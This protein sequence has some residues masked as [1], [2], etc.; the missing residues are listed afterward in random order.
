MTKYN[1]WYETSAKRFFVIRPEKIKLNKSYKSHKFVEN[2][3]GQ[4]SPHITPYFM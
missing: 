3:V 2:T 1:Q 4:Y